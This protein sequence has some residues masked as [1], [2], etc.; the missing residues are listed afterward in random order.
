MVVVPME[1]YVIEDNVRGFVPVAMTARCFTCFT[2]WLANRVA[3]LHRSCSMRCCPLG[4]APKAIGGGEN[5]RGDHRSPDI[6]ETDRSFHHGTLLLDADLS[7]RQTI[8]KSDK[9][10][11]GVSDPVGTFPR[12]NLT[13]E[14]LRIP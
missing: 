1:E 10:L 11:G 5:R 8:S 4:T 2:L 6:A 13:S 7:R 12:D 3:H 9:K 14:L